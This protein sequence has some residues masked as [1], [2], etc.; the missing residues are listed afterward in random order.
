[1]KQDKEFWNKMS[2]GYDAQVKSKFYETYNKTIEV[3]KK[4]LKNTDIVLDYACGTGI[5]TIELCENVK[6][7]NAIDISENM[8]NIGKEKSE[9]R[10]IKNIQF[11]V[12]D[13]Y[14]E[15]LQKGSFDVIIGFNI[16]Y[17]I[18]DIDNVIKRINELLKP[19]GIF[20]STTD[21][22]GE[23]KSIITAIECLLSKMGIIPYIKMLKRNELKELIKKYDFSIIETQT[24]YNSPPN[25]FIVARKS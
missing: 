10:N 8:I 25:Y 21:C 20:I 14:D 16:L 3:T 11:N 22:L 12:M 24:L 19:N 15:G 9:K 7:I 23:K 4:Y 18:R 1:M 5:T 13:I 17:F 2:K 6:D